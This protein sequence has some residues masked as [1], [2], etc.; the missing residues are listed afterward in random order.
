[1]SSAAKS[2]DVA[3]DTG[4]CITHEL[5]KLQKQWWCFLLLGVAMIILGTL[6][7]G[8]SFFVTVVT[9]VFFGVLMLIGGM[10]QVISAFWAGDWGGMLLHLLIGLMYIIVGFFIIDAPVEGAAG[11]T[12]VVSVFLARGNKGTVLPHFVAHMDCNG[13]KLSRFI[14]RDGYVEEGVR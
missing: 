2:S 11:L 10:A 3:A 13:N 8:S 4:T 12:L 9:V 14:V 1:M 6:A 7:L 5:E